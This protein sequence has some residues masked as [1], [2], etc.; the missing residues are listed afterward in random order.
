[1]QVKS[2]VARVARPEL[3]GFGGVGPR[4]APA[5]PSAGPRPKRDPALHR[6]CCEPGQH[7][8]LVRPLV[9]HAA[10]VPSAR[11][12]M[13]RQP[14]DVRGHGRQHLLDVGRVKRWARVEAH[15]VA[16]PREDA[17]ENEGVKMYVEIERAPKSLDDH[18]RATAPVHHAICARSPAEE[19]ENRTHGAPHNG[20][21]QGVV[22]G[23][24]VAEAVGQ[25]QHPLPH[26]HSREHAVDEVRGPLGH[27]PPAT[28]RTKRAPMTRKRGQTIEP[29]PRTPEPREASAERATSQKVAKLLFHEGGEALPIAEVSR[30]RQKRLKVFAHHMVQDARRGP[31]WLVGR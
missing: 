7:R 24:P 18:H 8:G 22:P 9:E 1:M 27:A 13:R 28:A 4:D 30:L 23:Q 25:T 21:A 10:I 14:P 17:I 15:R 16:V 19:A 6:G 12:A 26:G 31:P 20:A 11:T 29:T 2:V 3:R 5:D